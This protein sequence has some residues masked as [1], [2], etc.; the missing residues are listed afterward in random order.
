MA[1]RCSLLGHAYGDSEVEREREEQGNEV[2][3]TIREEQ[4]CARCG[5]T[6]LVSEN[7]EVTAIREPADESEDQKSA[8]GTADKDVSVD[9]DGDEPE[10]IADSATEPVE[11]GEDGHDAEFVEEGP[12]DTGEVPA[13]TREA[14]TTTD[15]ESEEIDPV[16]DDAVIL[17]ADDESDDEQERDR[18]HGEW[19]DSDDVRADEPGGEDWPSVDGEDEGFDAEGGSGEPED[20]EFGGGLRP[21]SGGSGEGETVVERPE[22]TTETTFTSV[23]SAPTPVESTGSGDGSQYVCPEC[24]FT[25]PGS[26]SSL[27][28]G[29]ICPECRS[30]YLA[31]R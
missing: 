29:D 26:G 13:A 20:V 15:D 16:E 9:A 24:G 18:G 19:P 5:K 14:G 28:A 8:A 22:G 10:D 27:R 31:E 21:E 23:D 25:A 12:D 17:D 6:R 1:L 7:K 30:G 3:V 2:V 4:T 11:A